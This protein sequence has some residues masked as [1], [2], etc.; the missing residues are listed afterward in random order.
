MSRLILPPSGLAIPKSAAEP[1]PAPEP[2]TFE[3]VKEL[4]EQAGRGLFAAMRV[5]E[6]G[7][8]GGPLEIAS[9]L[10]DVQAFVAEAQR[11]LIGMAQGE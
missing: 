6:A 11:G 1:P 8:A 9:I 5:I 2:E 4:V 7:A 3:V 10:A